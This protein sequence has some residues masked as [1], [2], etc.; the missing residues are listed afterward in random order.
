MSIE[1]VESGK[2]MPDEMIT[3]EQRQ[4][5]EGQSVPQDYSSEHLDEYEKGLAQSVLKL[6]EMGPEEFRKRSLHLLSRLID[7]YEEQAKK[8]PTFHRNPETYKRFL[9]LYRRFKTLDEFPDDIQDPI[10]VISIKGIKRAEELAF[11]AGKDITGVEDEATDGVSVVKEGECTYYELPDFDD[12]QEDGD[13]VRFFDPQEAED[14][15]IVLDKGLT[16]QG[17]RNEEYHSTNVSGPWRKYDADFDDY[18]RSILKVVG[19]NREAKSVFE[20]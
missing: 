19:L 9:A 13:I 18:S 17:I 1:D 11:V 2:T 3:D 15:K 16:D 8:E 6:K 5:G 12:F 20:S 14:F 7:F 4:S 10:K